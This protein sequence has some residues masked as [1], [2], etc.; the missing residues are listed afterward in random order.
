MS[1]EIKNPLKK[2]NINNL[3]LRVGNK[4]FLKGNIALPDFRDGN[5]APFSAYLWK[6]HVSLEDLERFHLPKGTAN[7]KFEAPVSNLG[8]LDITNLSFQGSIEKMKVKVA[9]LK[10]NI[11]EV[12]LLQSI[13]IDNKNNQIAFAP[14]SK[15]SMAVKVVDFNLGSFLDNTELGLVS[16]DLKLN[17]DVNEKGAIA[18]HNMYANLRRFDFN[19]YAYANVSLQKGELVNDNLFADLQIK[20]PNVDLEYSGNISI[21][22]KQKYNF[23]LN[24][25]FANLGKLNFSED[26]TSKISTSITGN[27][28]G[29]TFENISGTIQ[30]NFLQYEEGGDELNIPVVNI[31]MQ[32]QKD[33]DKFS[34]NSS[35]IAVNLEGKID[36]NTVL[37]DFLEDLALVLPSLNV[38]KKDLNKQRKLSDFS[39]QKKWREPSRG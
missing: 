18:L 10:T 19:D 31:A 35:I 30:A 39:F 36:Y 20:D 6:G 32:R 13:Q 16:G 14:I 26:E 24:L 9:S 2:L 38:A 12:R 3:D 22:E 8:S 17:G 25:D 7:L 37:D 21:G 23:D 15:D 11:G 27:L 34:I 29:E 1:G 28:S 4:T 33:Y 5:A